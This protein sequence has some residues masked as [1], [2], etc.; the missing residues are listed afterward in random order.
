MRTRT[1][2]LA[3]AALFVFAAGTAA[4]GVRPG[5]TLYVKSRNTRVLKDPSASAAVVVILQP[6]TAVTWQG[7]DAKD[8][9]WQRIA[10]GTQQGVVMT[11]NLSAEKP[12][13]EVRGSTSAAAADTSAFMSSGAASKA[14]GAGAIDYA[15]KQSAEASARQLQRVEAMAKT[16]GPRQVSDHAR[17]AGLNPVVGASAGTAEARR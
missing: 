2:P 16:I 3:L 11:A 8:R 10:V 17:K 5:D 9:R 1:L 15:R 13:E 4:A 6:G 7:P 12:K 14:L